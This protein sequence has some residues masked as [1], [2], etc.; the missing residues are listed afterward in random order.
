MNQTQYEW[1][2]TQLLTFGKVSRNEALR[3][4]ITRLGAIIH[5]LNKSGWSIVGNWEKTEFGKD[6]M[7]TLISYPSPTLG[8]TEIYQQKQISLFK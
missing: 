3:N 6:F 2:K 4:Y 8:K 5:S 7:Y 1:T